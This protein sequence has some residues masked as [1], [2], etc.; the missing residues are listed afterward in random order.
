MKES[1]ETVLEDLV[2]ARAPLIVIKTSEEER[3]LDAIEAVAK[4]L[5][6]LCI[7]FDAADGFHPLACGAQTSPVAKDP[8]SALDQVDKA[9]GSNLSLY[10]FLD[11]HE[12]WGNVQV[13]RKL[14]NL[15]Q[16]LKYTKTSLIVT[17]PAA[18]L[19]EELM[20]EAEVVEFRLPGVPELSSVLAKLERTPGVQVDLTDQGRQ[21]L[22]QAALGLTASQAQHAFGQAVISDG[23]VDE[24]AISSVI[25]KKKRIIA[26]SRTLQFYEVT[27][28]MDHV[29][30]LGCLKEWLHQRGEAF[31]QAARDF[32]LPFPKGLLLIGI[33]GTGKSLAAK[34]IA[35]EWH[36][37][38]LH[39]NVGLVY[40]SL[41]GD[42]ETN[43]HKALRLAET[44]APCILWIDELEKALARGGR[45]G[46]TSER[47]FGA[48]LTWMQEKTAPVFVVAT[49]NN[50]SG[51]PPE[52]LRKGRFDEIFFFDLPTLEE[53]TEIFK[54]HLNK[55]GRKPEAFN[56]DDLAQASEGYVGSE[57]E[58][59]VI[60]ALYVAFH[61]SQRPLKTEDIVS[62]LRRQVPLSVSQSEVIGQ[63][64]QW[65]QQGRARSAS[66]QTPPQAK[67]P[68]IPIDLRHE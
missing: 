40:G 15:A 19:P 7:V 16:R 12:F 43:I 1:F 61:Q 17:C 56:L 46:G 21:Q 67:Q 14:R 66:F 47:V 13:K 59:S 34:V 58:Q 8:L 54:I 45:D 25:R 37:P 24:G 41:V 27:E 38:L 51:L 50:I 10:V 28:T 63:L 36:M 3:A 42:S 53:R 49:A 11:F 68:V 32:G 20:D 62:A 57:I 22:V 9:D 55:C 5:N 18:N 30:G 4:R 60:E 64:R 48:I 2:R 26:E 35:H 44:V 33:S 31:S 23:T 52:L 39:F 6:W 65:L 29:G